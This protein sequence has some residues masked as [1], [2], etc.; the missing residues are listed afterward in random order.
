MALRRGPHPPTNAEE[1]IKVLHNE[2]RGKL[3]NGYAKMIRY[4]EL[5]KN[6]PENLKISP[7][8]MIPHKSRSYCTILD[9]S[10]Q[11]RHRGTMMQ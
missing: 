5:N 4:E 9:L 6:L 10:F 8:A 2:T 1:A 7:V 11:L 3:A